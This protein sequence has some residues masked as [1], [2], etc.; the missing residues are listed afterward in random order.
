[1][2]TD[3]QEIGGFRVGDRVMVE[4]AWED[5]TGAYHDEHAEI[6][7][8]MSD[9]TAHLEFDLGEYDP[10]S[11]ESVKADLDLSVFTVEDLQLVERG[12]A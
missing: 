11:F 10:E 6:V 7:A 5:E 9:G 3:V 4:Q 12:E 8:L 2:S 1:M